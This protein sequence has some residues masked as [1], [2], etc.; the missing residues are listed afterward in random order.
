MFR[1]RDGFGVSWCNGWM[2]EGKKL[3]REFKGRGYSGQ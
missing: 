2:F 1:S 3:T